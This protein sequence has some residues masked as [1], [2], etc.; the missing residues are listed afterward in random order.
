MEIKEMTDSNIINSLRRAAQLAGSWQFARE[1]YINSVEADATFSETSRVN[2]KFAFFDNG[3]GIAPSDLDQY[4]NARNSSSK[5][6][7]GLHQNYGIGLKDTALWYNQYGVVIVSKTEECPHGGMIWLSIDW[8]S[9]KAGA[10]HLIS[11]E[12][13]KSGY[14]GPGEPVIDFKH[15]SSFTIDGIDFT[16]LFNKKRRIKKSGTAIILMGNSKT[17]DTFSK[18][19]SAKLVQFLSSRLFSLPIPISM[20]RP[21]GKVQKTDNLSDFSSI[22]NARII[23]TM[24]YQGFEITTSIIL[25][26]DF[27]DKKYIKPYSER[28]NL[29][30]CKTFIDFILYQNEMYGYRL[31]KG[32]AESRKRAEK[33]GIYYSSVADRVRICIRPPMADGLGSKG[34]YPNSERTT[35]F[36]GTGTAES[37]PTPISL[38]EIR[39]YYI[40]N[41]PTK[42][43]ELLEAAAEA[44]APAKSDRNQEWMQSWVKYQGVSRDALRPGALES[45]RSSSNGN[46]VPGV[47]GPLFEPPKKDSKPKQNKPTSK[48]KSKKTSRG[49]ADKPKTILDGNGKIKAK[50]KTQTDFDQV[51]FIDELSEDQIENIESYFRPDTDHKYWI[52]YPMGHGC[53]YID[54]GCSTIRKGAHVACDIINERVNDKRK[55][56]WSRR[57]NYQ[58]VLTHIIKP[59]LKQ[60]LPVQIRDLA[61]DQDM[62]KNNQSP[63]NPD[64]IQ[65]ILGGGIWGS[66]AVDNHDFY[67]QWLKSLKTTKETNEAS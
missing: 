55:T 8:C 31:S 47:L 53:I 60:V 19:S 62:I 4:I 38:G 7:G 33:W 61:T 16:K 34:V 12:M 45:Y 52:V 57:V 29:C 3:C 63:R 48:P 59:Y 28:N 6:T 17:E 9:G 58:E 13:I 22:F 18:L 21:T 32:S 14:S 46:E 10:K 27:Y 37:D 65:Q 30:K 50:R 54:E 35:L 66:Y 36:W 23:D 39:K 11:D 67:F 41:M 5:Q 49:S 15:H 42:L 44:Q 56:K 24:S 1:L 40:E 64:Q 26:S 51:V 43:E 20:N 2:D 25:E